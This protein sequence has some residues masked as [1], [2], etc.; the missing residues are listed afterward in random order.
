QILEA[1]L[2]KL[3]SQE[4]IRRD[5]S[6]K[7]ALNS[8]QKKVEIA[9]NRLS[10]YKALS[11][12]DSGEQ[13]RDLSINIE[14][15]RRQQAEILA[16]QQQASTRLKQLSANLN[17][18]AQQAADAFVLQTDQIFQQNLKDYSES[19]AALDVLSSKFLPN[20]PQVVAQRAAR[21][22]AQAALLKRSQSLLGR[23]V[24]QAILQQLNLSNSNSGSPRERLF[25][26]LITVQADQKGLQVQAQTL[27]RQIAK[28]ED[29]H[30]KLAQQ[31]STLDALSRDRQ[32]AETVFSSTLTKTDLDKSNVFGSYPLLQIVTEPT[33]AE[34][35][36]WPN[37][38][39]VLIG[40]ALCSFLVDAGIVLMWLNQR[41]TLISK[42]VKSTRIEN[43]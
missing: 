33:L 31:E 28:L 40:T 21:D 41:N 16:Q 15:L 18:S 2:D 7:T 26:E 4:L 9:Q 10:N 32:V 19:S 29:R 5:A 34:I 27:A 11:G 22:A 25:Q 36:T 37:K 39:F 24:D 23:Q 35:P 20:Y 12:L 1:R 30:K 14:Q 38:G 8:S 42:K 3:R 43:Q 6:S 13:L 17:L